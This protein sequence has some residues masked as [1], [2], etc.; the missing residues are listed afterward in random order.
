MTFFRNIT[1]VWNE[2]CPYTDDV[3]S[4][5]D[6]YQRNNPIT[7][8]LT[9]EAS[10]KCRY[11]HIIFHIVLCNF[12]SVLPMCFHE[13]LFRHWQFLPLPFIMLSEGFWGKEWT[14]CVW[15]WCLKVIVLFA[16]RSGLWYLMYM[17]VCIS[18]CVNRNNIKCLKES[19]PILKSCGARCGDIDSVNRA[20]TPPKKVAAIEKC[21]LVQYKV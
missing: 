11:R 5:V 21:Y 3:V 17:F 12:T 15:L 8:F 4:F 19:A 7:Y 14:F 10:F 20:P 1:L 16:D 9:K 13:I 18:Y 6:C 2:T